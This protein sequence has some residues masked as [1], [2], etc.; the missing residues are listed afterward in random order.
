MNKIRSILFIFIFIFNITAL[1]D[2]DH[3][4]QSVYNSPNIHNI[5]QGQKNTGAALGLAMG[6][7][8]CEYDTFAGQWFAGVGHY[9]GITSK[10]VGLCKRFNKILFTGGFGVDDAENIFDST[11]GFNIGING[12]F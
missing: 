3:H 10:A 8:H 2:G 5:T 1:A 7:Q 12:R 4:N 11:P 6:A 9:N